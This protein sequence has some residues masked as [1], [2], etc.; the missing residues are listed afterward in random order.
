M[1]LNQPENTNNFKNNYDSKTHP[2]AVL[3]GNC[4]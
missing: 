4:R 3:S 1:I 2:A